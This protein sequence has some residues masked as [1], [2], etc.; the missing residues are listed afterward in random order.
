MRRA[1]LGGVDGDRDAVSI[2]ERHGHDRRLI[3]CVSSFV[4]PTYTDLRPNPR[5]GSDAGIAICRSTRPA[6]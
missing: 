3:V 6:D 1:R 4:V 5:I 2:D